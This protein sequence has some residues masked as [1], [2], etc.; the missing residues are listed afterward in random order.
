MI[1][2]GSHMNHAFMQKLQSRKDQGQDLGSAEALLQEKPGMR[3]GQIAKNFDMDPA[4]AGL[5]PAA[6]ALA[7]A[8]GQQDKLGIVDGEQLTLGTVFANEVIRRLEG[9]DGAPLDSEGQPKNSDDLRQSLGQTMDWIRE[10]FGDETA[11]AAA[12]MIL[13]STASGVT[14]DSLS[15]GL[16]NTLQ[17]ID[18]NFGFAA[19]D[20]AIA[21]FNGSL[22]D[23][24]N[25]YFENGQSELFY[26]VSPAETGEA[27]QTQN[28]S[29]RFFSHAVQE[30]SDGEIIDPTQQ[31]LEE[32][33]KQLDETAQLQDLTS[34]IEA[35]INPEQLT[36]Q[37]AA[38]AY[39]DAYVPVEP[40]LT[41][42]AV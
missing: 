42:M 4:H 2:Q 12:G 19:G 6:E 30:A 20:S 13:Q 23:S 26:A 5:T 39:N 27:S 15:D 32:L 10:R 35:Q 25:G 29:A 3:L 21:Q 9:A 16:L 24:L 8:P 28:L 18:R 36:Q 7:K 41:S 34:K 22:N 33:Q 14:E 37:A 1:I 31:L 40:Q 11:S 17:F 38:N